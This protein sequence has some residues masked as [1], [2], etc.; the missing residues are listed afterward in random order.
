MPANPGSK[1]NNEKQ[2]RKREQA[3]KERQVAQA[4]A[5]E[6]EKVSAAQLS[7]AEAAE[8]AEAAE[9]PYQRGA[10]SA[11]FDELDELASSIPD[12]LKKKKIEEASR[13]AAEIV[14]R[15]PK[16]PDGWQGFARVHEARGDYEKAIAEMERA[17][18]RVSAA[19]DVTA[20]Q[21]AKDL[22]R[23]RAALAKKR[24]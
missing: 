10:R 12:L 7:E 24:G 15:F 20:A 8:A 2:K 13:A 14:R 18:E 11:D 17:A 19:D 22:V 1:R 4:R 6:R 3:R 23:L 9:S 16:E 5:K 21:I